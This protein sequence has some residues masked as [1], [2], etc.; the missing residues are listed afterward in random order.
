MC[1][2]VMLLWQRLFFLNQISYTFEVPSRDDVKYVFP[3][4][5]ITGYRGQV[6]GLVEKIEVFL[7]SIVPFTRSRFYSCG[8]FCGV[9]TPMLKEACN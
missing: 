4:F 2:C 6:N 7:N 5:L 8:A 1:V 3:F 9:S